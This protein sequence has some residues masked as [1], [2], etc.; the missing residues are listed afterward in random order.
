MGQLDGHELG[1]ALQG[2]RGV[3]GLTWMSNRDV[4]RGFLLD[5]GHDV[6]LG[7]HTTDAAPWDTE[8]SER[9][10]EV[11][12]DVGRAQAGWTPTEEA[13]AVEVVGT[14]AVSPQH[15]VGAEWQVVCTT[16]A[17][18]ADIGTAATGVEV[19]QHVRVGQV[20]V[21]H[22]EVDT[23]AFD[24]GHQEVVGAVAAHHTWHCVAGW[25]EGV[26]AVPVFV[27]AVHRHGFRLEGGRNV[28][29]TLVVRG[30]QQESNLSSRSSTQVGGVDAHEV[31]FVDDGRTGHDDLAADE[32]VANRGDV[33]VVASVHLRGGVS[34]GHVLNTTGGVHNGQSRGGV[35]DTAVPAEWRVFNIHTDGTRGV[36]GVDPNIGAALDVETGTGAA[37]VDVSVDGDNVGVLSEHTVVATREVSA[38]NHEQIAVLLAHTGGV[39]AHVRTVEGQDRVGVVADNTNGRGEVIT[40][41]GGTNVAEVTVVENDGVVA[42]VDRVGSGLNGHG[43][44]A[45]G[46]D[47]NGVRGGSSRRQSDGVATHGWT[48]VA[49]R[50]ARG[51]DHTDGGSTVAPR[52][53][54][55]KRV[56]ASVRVS[57]E[58]AVRSV[59]V[60]RVGGPGVLGAV[61]L[62][63]LNADF[64]APAVGFE[65]DHSGLAGGKVPG[66]A[67][68]ASVVAATN[69]TK[70]V[71]R[72]RRCAHA[73]EV[74]TTVSIRQGVVGDVA[75][76]I[77][78]VDTR[79]GVV[80]DTADVV[81]VNRE[82][83][84]TV[85]V[86]GIVAANDRVVLNQDILGLPVV[87]GHC[88]SVG[89]VE[90]VVG[91]GHVLCFVR[92]VEPNIC[93]FT[94]VV[95]DVV[96]DRQVV[97][98]D[99]VGVVAVVVG[100]ALSKD[101]NTTVN[102]VVAV[103]DVAIATVHD[104]TNVVHVDGV[105][106]RRVAGKVDEGAVGD[107]EEV[108]L[109]VVVVAVA[110]GTDDR[111][112]TGNGGVVH[113]NVQRVVAVA[114]D[115]ALW[116]TTAGHSHGGDR[117][118]VHVERGFAAVVRVHTVGTVEVVGSGGDPRGTIP[119]VLA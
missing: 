92:G 37:T 111:G 18:V 7:W 101:T 14:F 42:K 6:D 22:T 106:Q 25:V 68:R 56:V 79:R 93:D 23:V 12:V 102:E 69:R 19:N 50:S 31:G 4:S 10:G 81:A 97:N 26:A 119:V 85:E 118:V 103:D 35:S 76:S 74:H 87:D 61:G 29:S 44:T 89:R 57:T 39:A 104:D 86:E 98:T 15:V 83:I 43:V 95:E 32:G 3:Q 30:G 100:R 53:G 116:S 17:V 46:G 91:D 70:R 78:D 67:G 62:G 2:S 48:S 88:V 51:F 33:S 5:D 114:E 41:E 20:A 117:G 65:V 9:G 60:E 115:E 73:V 107:L 112:N 82:V 49:A 52:V 71:G 63:D 24:V 34:P 40:G 94:A 58:W 28:G 75:V 55:S 8:L 84:H 38:A 99:L 105:V 96:G 13:V 59:A 77:E 109:V 16:E 66:A 47:T 64:I 113:V 90:F 27:R 1:Q 36:H 54:H 80:A 72:C 110:H 21:G 45:R 11:H 108:Q